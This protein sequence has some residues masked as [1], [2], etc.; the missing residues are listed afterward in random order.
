VDAPGVGKRLAEINATYGE[1]CFGKRL[2]QVD[3]INRRGHAAG[4]A[5]VAAT[6]IISRK[7]GF[8]QEQE[9]DG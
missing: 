6:F 1:A 7:R 3:H 9:A 8:S 2:A 5:A 4:N